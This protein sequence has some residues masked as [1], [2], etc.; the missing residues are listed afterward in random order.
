[1]RG[2]VYGGKPVFCGGNF[3]PER[4]PSARISQGLRACLDEVANKAGSQGMKTPGPEADQGFFVV[5]LW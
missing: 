2:A 1:M 4:E 3:L 5:N